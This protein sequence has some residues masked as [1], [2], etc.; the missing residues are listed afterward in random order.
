MQQLMLPASR[1]RT[2]PLRLDMPGCPKSLQGTSA[3]VSGLEPC[4]AADALPI[5]IS[6]QF[7]FLRSE[8]SEGSEAY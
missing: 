3:L 1:V 8:F 4:P 2:P 7:G 5:R 6:W